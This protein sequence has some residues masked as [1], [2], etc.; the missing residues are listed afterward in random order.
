MKSSNERPS[1]RRLVIVASALYAPVARTA[2]R[3]PGLAGEVE[4]L[5]EENAQVRAHLLEM[6]L[7]TRFG[8]DDPA[9]P[10]IAEELLGDDAPLVRVAALRFFLRRSGTVRARGPGALRQS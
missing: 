6:C 1:L 2:A 4:R 8:R 3:V 5:R 7:N 10:L 9:Y